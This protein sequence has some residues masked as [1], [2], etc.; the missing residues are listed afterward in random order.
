MLRDP[1]DRTREGVTSLLGHGPAV[2]SMRNLITQMLSLFFSKN[3]LILYR[4]RVGAFAVFASRPDIVG[5]FKDLENS[6]V[7]FLLALIVI[8]GPYPS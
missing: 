7:L 6:R 8:V 2:I 5:W 3:K 1:R 4:L